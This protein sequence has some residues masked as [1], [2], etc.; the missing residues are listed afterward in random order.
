VN[1]VA[2]PLV[3]AIMDAPKSVK[4]PPILPLKVEPKK[5]RPEPSLE[6]IPANDGMAEVFIL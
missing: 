4:T 1:V 2:S 3:I 5:R 6:L